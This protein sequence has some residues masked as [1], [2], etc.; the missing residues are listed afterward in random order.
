MKIILFIFPL[1]FIFSINESQLI[2]SIIIH[3][4]KRTQNYI[5]KREL[6]HPMKSVIDSALLN[7]DINRLYNLGIFSEVDIYVENQIYNVNIVE[8]FSVIPIIDIEYD[9]LKD[10]F[11]Y[12]IGL[13][14]INF[15]G[16]KQ[17][18]ALVTSFGRE[19]IYFLNLYN[20]WVFGDHVSI[21]TILGNRRTENI[22]YEF[23]FDEKFNSIEIGFYRGLKNR[24]KFNLE[25]Y[26]NTIIESSISCNT[27]DA[28]NSKPLESNYV[29]SNFNYQ[30][31]TRDISSV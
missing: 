16:R 11:T 6:L 30:Y 25:Y 2:D 1:S 19:K 31:D 13:A 4:N 29:V 26:K 28:V 20:P 24:F 12:M 7:D 18:L 3:G 10:D 17:E 5:I 22:F 15:F 27:Y 14:D 8:S 9:E 23:E 21:R